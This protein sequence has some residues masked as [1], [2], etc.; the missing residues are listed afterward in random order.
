MAKEGGGI[1][2]SLGNGS[3]QLIEPE[4]VLHTRKINKSFDRIQSVKTLT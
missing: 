3:P 1:E 2:K 4:I